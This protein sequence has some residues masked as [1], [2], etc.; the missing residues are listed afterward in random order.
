MVDLHS[1]VFEPFVC[2]IAYVVTIESDNYHALIL[3]RPDPGVSLAPKTLSDCE[4]LSHTVHVVADKNTL[5][6]ISMVMYDEI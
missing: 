6:H 1:S 2:L 4:P 3:I 5:S